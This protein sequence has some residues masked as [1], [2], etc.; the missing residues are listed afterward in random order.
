MKT[1]KNALILIRATYQKNKQSKN[2][3]KPHFTENN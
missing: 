2:Y 3:A 1:F